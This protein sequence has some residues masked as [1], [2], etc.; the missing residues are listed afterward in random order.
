MPLKQ[1]ETETFV[2][3]QLQASRYFFVLL[4]HFKQ[5][6]SIKETN[7]KHTLKHAGLELLSLQLQ[8]TRC[9]QWRPSLEL[10]QL[11]CIVATS[12]RNLISPIQTV[13][14]TDRYLY[15]FCCQFVVADITTTTLTLINPSLVL[16]SILLP[17]QI[18]RASN[19][20]YILHS[21]S[22]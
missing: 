7:K 13:E 17:W 9:S 3:S 8:R 10:A 19:T 2:T 14:E 15:Y 11:S 16:L 12:P 4:L 20:S 22:I 21:A 18:S 6:F 5:N 1:L